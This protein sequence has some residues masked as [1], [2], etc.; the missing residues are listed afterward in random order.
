MLGDSQHDDQGMTSVV[1]GEDDREAGRGGPPLV[2]CDAN[3][4]T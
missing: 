2:V 3:V 1:D 4:H